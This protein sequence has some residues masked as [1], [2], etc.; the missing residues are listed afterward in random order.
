MVG[1]YLGCLYTYLVVNGI[2]LLRSYCG[3]MIKK[4]FLR[5]I[6]IANEYGTVYRYNIYIHCSMI[7]YRVLSAR[8]CCGRAH[9]AIIRTVMVSKIRAARE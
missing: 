3:S 6:I 8:S 2:D 9:T 7:L 5:S 1:F 4:L